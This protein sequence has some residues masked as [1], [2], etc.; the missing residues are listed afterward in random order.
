M[1]SNKFLEKEFAKAI[2]DGD[3]HSFISYIENGADIVAYENGPLYQACEYGHTIIV[4]HLL[5]YESVRTRAHM[6][7][8]RCLI[9]AQ[10]NEYDDIEEILLALPNVAAGMSLRKVGFGV[11]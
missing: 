7:A 3:Y 2:A 11:L 10:R 9:A 8:N 4:N 5:T 6:H 1:S